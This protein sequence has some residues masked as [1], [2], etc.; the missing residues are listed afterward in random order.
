MA[1][2]PASLGATTDWAVT[3]NANYSAET[4]ANP[5]PWGNFASGT[6]QYGSIAEYI[7]ESANFYY[8]SINSALIIFCIGYEDNL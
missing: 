3:P 6:P 2:N 4:G 5:P 1:F 8:A 7:I